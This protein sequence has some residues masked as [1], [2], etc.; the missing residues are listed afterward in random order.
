M[1]NTYIKRDGRYSGPRGTML[2]R[3]EAVAAGVDLADLD[4]ADAA[5][6]KNSERLERRARIAR[7]VGDPESI[8]GTQAD[9]I[10]LLVAISLAQIA[11]LKDVATRDNVQKSM[12]AR[13][14]AIVG[15]DVDIFA[16]ADNALEHIASG[17]IVLTAAVKGV[18]NVLSEAFE[19]STKA[20]AILS[21]PAANA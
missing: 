21:A 11:A 12:I 5:A 2:T 4:A 15:T 20:A 6:I 3:D 8:L 17:E 9:I 13:I 18:E 19:R 16:L 14:E 7:E 10:G 1:A